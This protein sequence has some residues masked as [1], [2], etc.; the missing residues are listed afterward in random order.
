MLI[1]IRD[2]EGTRLASAL[3]LSDV[4]GQ[5]VDLLVRYRTHVKNDGRVIDDWR[6]AAPDI[7]ATAPEH[8]AVYSAGW[9]A[10]QR[11]LFL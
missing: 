11:A 7:S 1:E 9:K 6:A 4:I 2:A 8:V 3:D 10:A 5:L